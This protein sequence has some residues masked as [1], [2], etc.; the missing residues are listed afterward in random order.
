VSGRLEHTFDSDETQAGSDGDTPPETTSPTATVDGEVVRVVAAVDGLA[1]DDPAGLGWVGQRERLRAVGRLVDRL[2]AQRI[3]LLEAA[4]R[5]G[6]LADDGA[7]TAASWLRR[8]ST[9]T[10]TQAADRAKLAR[11]LPELPVIAAAFADG[12]LGVAHVTQIDR[13]C[14]DVGVDQVA[15]V[16]PELVTAAGRLRDVGQF[17][18]LCVG[19]RHALRPDLADA[20]DDRAHDQR[21]L[22]HTPTFDGAFHLSG[23]FDAVAGA[24]IAA[25]INATTDSSAPG[26]VTRS[27]QNLTC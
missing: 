2:E 10:A 18:R 12:T 5:S 15:A 25:A 11:R 22:S 9:L 27:R 16:Q 17:T 13:L 24:T 14:R 23:V 3:R 20:A 4:D 7:A 6:A 26:L 21:R 8:H 1:A 19:W